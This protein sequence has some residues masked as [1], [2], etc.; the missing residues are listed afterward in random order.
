MPRRT[1]RTP[2][3]IAAPSV[4]VPIKRDVITLVL[5]RGDL[6]E[7]LKPDGKTVAFTANFQDVTLGDD[8][9]VKEI[10][11]VGAETPKGARHIRTFVPSRIRL[12]SFKGWISTMED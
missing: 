7:V 12:P 9:L 10:T 8:G 4:K 5:R 1:A 3:V 6:V 11:V 2:P